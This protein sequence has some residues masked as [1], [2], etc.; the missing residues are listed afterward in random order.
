MSATL[1]LAPDVSASSELEQDAADMLDADELVPRFG[2]AY[3]PMDEEDLDAQI[4][5]HEN[6]VKSWYE[7]VVGAWK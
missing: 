2:T 7:G 3:E 4:R 6:F 5:E 1:T